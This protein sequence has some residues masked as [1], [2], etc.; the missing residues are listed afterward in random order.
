MLSTLAASSIGPALSP[1]SSSNS[2][3]A[4]S[5]AVSPEFLRAARQRP[6]AERRRLGAA[7]QQHGIWLEQHDADPNQGRAGYSRSLMACCTLPPSSY[8]ARTSPRNRIGSEKCPSRAAPSWDRCWLPPALLR[9]GPSGPP[10]RTLKISHQFPGGT[11]DQGDFRDRL[12]PQV[13]RRGREAHQR[14]AEGR[15]L[16]RARR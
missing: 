4:A 6:L 10:A 14:R 12:V 3:R 8:I 2:R 11:A 16:S 1:A 5:S 13:R 15:G 7:D 9:A